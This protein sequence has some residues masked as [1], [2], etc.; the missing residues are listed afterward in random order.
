LVDAP[1]EEVLGALKYRQTQEQTV[2][3]KSGSIRNLLVPIDLSDDIR[4][5]ERCIALCKVKK[6]KDEDK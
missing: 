6:A 4:A 1:H 3:M 5:V 2:I